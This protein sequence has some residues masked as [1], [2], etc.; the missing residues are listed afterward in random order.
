[1]GL[2]GLSFSPSARHE[3]RVGAILLAFVLVINVLFMPRD[4]WESWDARAQRM[5]VAS[6]LENHH[7]WVTPQAAMSLG[8]PGQ[9][10]VS[11]PDNGHWYSKYGIIN[12]V[13][14]LPPTLAENL[15]KGHPSS[16]SQPSL[17]IFSAWNIFLSLALA[18]TLFVITRRYSNSPWTRAAYVAACLFSTYLWYYQRAQGCGE[19]FQTLFFAL[20]YECLLRALADEEVI[21]PRWL[22]A[23]WLFAGLLTLSRVFYGILLPVIGCIS[24]VTLFRRRTAGR[25]AM[26][27][28][29]VPPV[30]IVALLGWINTVKFGSPFLTGYHQWHPAEHLPVGSISTGLFGLL[31]TCHWSVF[32]YFPLL[33]L[34]IPGLRRFASQYK[35][36][37]V[38]ICSMFLTT[39]LV[40]A[41]IPTW[42][43]ERTYGP[44]YMLFILPIAALP[45][46]EWMR[47]LF[48]RR[49]STWGW[50]T[51]ALIAG[52]LG[53]SVW[54]QFETS[55]APFFFFY[56]IE[57]P[58]Q[59]HMDMDLAEYFYD[60]PEALLW[61][62][63]QEHRDDLD[64]TMLFQRLSTQHLMTDAELSEYRR[65]LIAELERR[66]FRWWP[67]PPPIKS[68]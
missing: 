57:S 21:R 61:H 38:A 45:A 32:V 51:P 27:A 24:L 12:A 6:F 52:L 23:A 55:E 39:L 17:L 28:A 19:I 46:L 58:L 25:S 53:F 33:I 68:N 44:R 41:M 9:Y 47:M 8:E 40:L 4:V 37:T 2:P 7:L 14:A 62:D 65:R 35:F 60:R 16:P 42:R 50:L 5:E 67:Q 56:E 18:A 1:M 54:I 10:F 49:R 36:D 29:I 63:L 31:F 34:A 3:I 15:I 30:A 48:D 13:M 11:N 22:L 20:A 43:G 66:N 26:L 64:Q 59:G